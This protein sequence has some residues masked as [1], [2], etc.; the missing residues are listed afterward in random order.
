[1]IPYIGGKNN[2]AKWIAPYIPGDIETYVEVFGGAYWVYCKSD[3]HKKRDLKNIVYNDF[4]KHMANLFYCLRN[5]DEIY[6]RV[7][8]IEAQNENLFNQY[9]KEVRETIDFELGD[10]DLAVK[11][12]YL[13]T[14]VFSGSRIMTTGFI[15]LEPNKFDMF[16]RKISQWKYI[17][18]LQKI[19]HI[20]NIDYSEVIKKYDNEKT[21]FYV[22]PPY[23]KTED[24]YS[25]HEFDREDHEKLCNQLKNIKGRFALSYYDFPLLKEWLPENKYNWERKA[26]AKKAAAKKGIKQNKGTELL[27]LNY[28]I[29]QLKLF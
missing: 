16:K 14:Q 4:N 26:F 12:I 6:K 23:W 7:K 13:A 8:D 5:P 28:P 17:E 3:I 11:Y 20:E 29:K 24:Y 19:T 22:D 21:F 18:K 15:K 25:N 9:Q 1:M 2:M 27:I 10:Y